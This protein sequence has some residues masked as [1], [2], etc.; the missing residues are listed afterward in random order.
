VPLAGLADH[1]FTAGNLQ[2]RDNEQE[3]AAVAGVLQVAPADIL[4]IRQVHRA[5]VAVARYGR[6]GSWHR[7][8]ADVIVSDDPSVAIGVRVADCAPI[9]LADRDR[10]AVAAVH[11][12]WRGTVERAAMAAV[13]ALTD[14]FGVVPGA[15]VAAIGPCLGPCCGEVGAEVVDTFRAAGHD[16]HDITAWFSPS[17]SGKPYLDLWRANRD[18]LAA[19]GISPANIHVAALCTK[20]HSELFH[21][22]RAAGPHAGRMLGVIKKKR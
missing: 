16:S 8:D 19:A 12:G 4:L 3:W 14:G 13:R 18:Q 6:V 9:L 7:P 20:S 21:S 2:L 11:A 22:Y 5:D 17:P 15:L 10:R 1:L